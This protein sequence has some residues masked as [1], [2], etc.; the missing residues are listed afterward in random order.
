MMLS[1]DILS[2]LKNEVQQTFGRSILTSRDCIEL[3]EE[4]Y[5]KT[6]EGVN[7]NTLRRLFGLIKSSYKPSIS[8]LRILAKYCSYDSMEDLPSLELN[9]D[10]GDVVTNENILHFLVNLYRE[11]PVNDIGNQTFFTL[12]KYTTLFF[13]RNPKLAF[14][15]Q[16]HI[17]KT[18][19][20]Q[21]Y[22]FEQFINMDKLNSY[23]GDGLRR[24]VSEKATSEAAIFTYSLLVFR[25]WLT[26]ETE[27][28]EHAF[29]QLIDYESSKVKDSST[30]A[31]NFASKLF[32]THAV[33][34][35]TDAVINN[36]ASFH[37][38][39]RARQDKQNNFPFFE[40]IVSEAL[41]L[42]GFY[43]EA[44]YYI[45]F[46]KDNYP[47]NHAY[48][49]LGYYKTLDLLKGIALSEQGF[50]NKEEGLILN[51][52]SNE[53]CFLSKKYNQILFYLWIRKVKK[54]C[55]SDNEHFKSLIKETGFIRLCYS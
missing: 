20:G 54:L 48:A 2:T 44:V 21:S 35:A 6:R 38:N 53:L 26:M 49:N 4:L 8:T 32:Y 14:Q 39:F 36:I 10:G 7:P 18:K 51:V 15:F 52:K 43:N 25:Y 24:Y 13:N 11:I 27:K 47:T 40:L 45:N 33:G 16:N 23:Y 3:S 17:A 41:V 22:Y 55:S 19:N 1:N 9:K 28:L 42:T 29:R 37:G 5:T 46:A 31:R 34:K 30:C 50:K 12:S